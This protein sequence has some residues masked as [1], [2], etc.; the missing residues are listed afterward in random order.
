M[1]NQSAISWGD[2]SDKFFAL[3]VAEDKPILLYIEAGWCYWSRQMENENFSDPDIAQLINE[4]FIPLR[5]DTDDRP[6]LNLRYNMGGWPSLAVLTPAGEVITGSTFLNKKDFKKF[7]VQCHLLYRNQK[8]EIQKRLQQVKEKGRQHIGGGSD[9]ITI[10]PDIIPQVLKFL[11]KDYDAVYGGFGRKPKFPHYEA[12][13]LASL[14][15]YLHG[16]LKI[17]EILTC[18]LDRMSEGGLFDREEGGFFRY[19]QKQDWTAP[20]YEKMLA[21]NAC[22]LQNYLHAYLITGKERYQNTAQS[23]LAYFDA[24]LY[25]R[26]QGVFF[27][28][29]RADEQYYQ[30]RGQERRFISAP[31]C[32]KI[33]YTDWNALAVSS[34]LKASAVLHEQTYSDRARRALNFLWR[35]CVSEDE[36]MG[37]LHSSHQTPAVSWRLLGDQV[38]MAR[39]LLDGYQFFGD[40]GYLTHASLLAKCLCSHFYDETG[41]FWDRYEDDSPK[42]RLGER[43][44]PILDNALAAEFFLKLGVLTQ[45]SEYITMVRRTLNFFSRDFSRY[46]IFASR[47]AFTCYLLEKSLLLLV[48]LG[49]REDNESQR[50]LQRMFRLYEPR[51]VIKFFDVGEHPQMAQMLQQ[52][53]QKA[54]RGYLYTGQDCLLETGDPEQLEKEIGKFIHICK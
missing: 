12:I 23:I 51:K 28:S 47:Y 8:E 49:R 9:T 32:G 44:K 29:Q 41:G 38:H 7:L 52:Q 16:D 53:G 18:T 10:P 3:A 15:F 48:V 25:D 42:G 20:H 26:D 2:W 43:I 19:A 1:K 35:H 13:E 45:N 5:I 50:F 22:L 40:E 30:L 27:G 34:Y 6:D 46:G 11:E 24:Y 14:A 33:I 37:M 54:P 31:S 21:D 4:Y 17:K 36:D 39:A